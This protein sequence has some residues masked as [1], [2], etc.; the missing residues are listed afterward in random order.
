MP[1]K[2]SDSATKSDTRHPQDSPQASPSGISEVLGINHIGLAPKDPA[3]ARW[4]FETALGLK[5][6]GQ[7]LVKE[8][9]TDTTMIAS[10]S[11]TPLAVDTGKERLEILVPENGQGP[12]A[13]FLE[14]KGSGIHHVALNV[15]GLLPLLARLKSLGVK[16]IDETPRR[17]AHHTN[18]AFVHPEA[19]GGLLVELVEQA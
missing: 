13:K 11:E 3:R 15:T 1:S 6:L 17:G 12:I 9:Q 2:P 7:E 16:L 19:A 8:Q 14:K 18:I 10:Y 5:N 4:F